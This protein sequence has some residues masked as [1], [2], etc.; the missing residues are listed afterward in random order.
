MALV[1]AQARVAP[2]Y[3][4]VEP[5]YTDVIPL[6]MQEDN[7]GIMDIM[8]A[9]Y[10]WMDGDGG[11]AKDAKLFPTSINKNTA[12]DEFISHIKNMFL[13]SFPDK[14]ESELRH[15]LNFA[16]NFYGSR[17]SPDSY[18]FLFNAIYGEEVEISYPGRNVLKT[19]DGVWRSRIV[20]KCV[21]AGTDLL[22]LLERRLY[23]VDSGAS[24][25][26][27]S[28]VSSVIDDKIITDATLWSVKG[29]FNIDEI[30]ETRDSLTQLR[31]RTLGQVVSA[32]IVSP[33]KGYIE[34]T[35]VQT[36]G[37][38]GSPIS[39]KIATVDEEGR[40]L[41]LDIIESGVNYVS[42]PPVLNL[43]NVNLFTPESVAGGT[44]VIAN[45]T[46]SIGATFT[47]PG[48]YI[49]LK[50]S[51]SAVSALTD[52]YFYHQY[53]YLL[54]S[55]VPVE[56]FEP[57][58]K[59]L[60]HPAGM[61]MFSKPSIV[62]DASKALNNIGSYW[63]EYSAPQDVNYKN[64][65]SNSDRKFFDLYVKVELPGLAK[66]AEYKV[67]GL[68]VTFESFLIGNSLLLNDIDANVEINKTLAIIT[69][70][71]SQSRLINI[72]SIGDP[73]LDVTKTYGMNL[74]GFNPAAL[75]IQYKNSS[76][77]I[78]SDIVKLS[79][80]LQ[81]YGTYE[82]SINQNIAQTP[83]A[84]ER[85][86]LFVTRSSSYFLYEVGNQTLNTFKLDID[87]YGLSPQASVSQI[88][89]LS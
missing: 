79:N 3:A 49:E 32:T 17:G 54:T 67:T 41:K 5:L 26:V 80:I 14:S 62:S 47:A 71:A 35:I 42:V 20:L 31:C 44:N 56:E 72:R 89:T 24:A 4:N 59:T 34:G 13:N 46:L 64:P 84:Y 11:I 10:K 29:S 83:I 19:S 38:D 75:G 50:S 8:S 51:T 27:K 18:K 82:I 81:N 15:I 6:H 66:R 39:V 60:L 88:Q 53:S 2:Q 28:L 76:A 55:A 45:I 36:S 1:K 9:Y 85:V 74:A 63:F 73:Y 23:G 57:V 12:S 77:E 30:L 22:N 86:D 16:R 68:T 43:S 48:E 25:I 33:G 70:S 7:S 40:I 58:V 52:G 21:F 78:S 87:S 37:G 65:N 61:I 69:N